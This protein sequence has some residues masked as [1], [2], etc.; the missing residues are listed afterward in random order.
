MLMGK[1]K[2]VNPILKDPVD[3]SVLEW[4][5][6]VMYVWWWKKR[7]TDYSVTTPAAN[8]GQDCQYNDGARKSGNCPGFPPCPPP[9]G[10]KIYA[11]WVKV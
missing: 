11:I 3:C 1:K 8:G 2:L 10:V 6:C 7:T 4:M 9:I 5:G